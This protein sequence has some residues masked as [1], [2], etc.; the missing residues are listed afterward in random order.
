M[1]W[2]PVMVHALLSG[3]DPL[4]MATQQHPSNESSS[5]SHAATSEG[6]LAADTGVMAVLLSA[7]PFSVAAVAVTLSGFAAQRTGRPLVFIIIPNFIGG[8]SFI[9]FHQVVTWSRTAG[10]MCLVITLSCAYVASPHA[11][12]IIARL[13]AGPAAAVAMPCFNSVAMLGGFIGPSIMGF[14]VQRLGGF[15]VASTVMGGSMIFAGCMAVVLQCIMWHSKHSALDTLHDIEEHQGLRPDNNALAADGYELVYR[16]SGLNVA[17]GVPAGA[18][19]AS[20]PQNV[21]EM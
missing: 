2:L 3:G 6:S 18:P 8:I 11:P 19:V 16:S 13:T 12:T 7:I 9:C 1:M 10:F 15:T 17:M 21:V 4:K 14:L 20:I 5:S